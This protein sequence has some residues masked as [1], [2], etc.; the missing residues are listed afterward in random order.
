MSSNGSPGATG[1]G[2]CSP[3]FSPAKKLILRLYVAGAGPNSVR[4]LANLDAL[5]RA[6][7]R[8]CF[9]IEIVDVL[10]QPQRALRDHV[11]VTPTLVKL[12]PPPV[13]Q[14]AGDLSERQ[15]VEYALGLGA[16]SS[17]WS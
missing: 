1:G 15:R 5:S 11:L 4:A 16:D 3:P 2:D 17:S 12:D 7:G 6:Y 13:V 10:V 9:E 8:D 14:I